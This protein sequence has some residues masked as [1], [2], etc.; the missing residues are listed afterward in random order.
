MKIFISK[1]KEKFIS[2]KQKVRLLYKQLKKTI[3][4]C[5]DPHKKQTIL[6][7]TI[8]FMLFCT[9]KTVNFFFSEEHHLLNK[10][11][12]ITE[13]E[14]L[15]TPAT[16]EIYK[17]E[18]DKAQRLSVSLLV[19]N[20]QIKIQ[21]EKLE[22][23]QNQL[24][25]KPDKSNLKNL[26]DYY[27]FFDYTLYTPR[28][29]NAVLNAIKNGQEVY[30]DINSTIKQVNLSEREICDKI[31][32][33]VPKADKSTLQNII[34]QA[35]EI[36]LALYIPNSVNQLTD[37]LIRA[38]FT[39]N[40]KNC[41][42]AE[43]DDITE[44]L[45]KTLSEMIPIPDKQQLENLLFSYDP[46]NEEKYSIASWEEFTPKYLQAKEVFNNLNATQA[47][48]NQA[49]DDLSAAVSMLAPAKGIFRV[50]IYADEIENNHVGNDWIFYEYINWQE[51]NYE[52][53]TA[54][55]NNSA[56]ASIKIIEQ[57]QYP[58]VGT[59]VVTFYFIDG[60]ETSF[61]VSVYEN[62]G[63][64]RGNRALFEVKVT[65]TQIGRE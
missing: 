21:T 59:G 4:E 19:S 25:F 41:N 52:G 61:Y 45:Q 34:N 57:D 26:I 51:I 35:E 58:D 12:T 6:V 1:A 44:E 49:Y 65:V 17:K 3:Y 8:L 54:I 29:K 28:S 40:D 47:E 2:L 13:D 18:Y 7:L 46:G 60:Y 14:K 31:K 62:R 33:L 9:Y 27:T 37:I 32:H 11:L 63:R 20:K 64:Y 55:Y 39:Y 10:A 16:Y 43:T 30:N 53:Y 42:Q 48:V 50:N 22:V 15:Y 36:D 24:E 56:T 23:A 5:Q 38:N